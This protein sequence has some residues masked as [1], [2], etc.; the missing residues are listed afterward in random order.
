[1]I[2]GLTGSFKSGKT[3]VAGMFRKKKALVIDADK[4]AHAVIERKTEAWKKIVARFGRRILNAKGA[5]N[6]EKLGE[7][8]FKNKKELNWL[9]G[10]IHP[11]VISEIKALVKKYKKLYPKR[12]IIVDVPLLL[13]AGLGSLVD[14][15]IVVDCRLAEQVKR[16]RLKT[17]LSRI[18]IL[19][20]VNS[21]LPLAKKIKL[22]DFVINNNGTLSETKKQVDGIY[23]VLPR[24]T[25]GAGSNSPLRAH[26]RR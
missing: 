12:I 20:R 1:M 13:E 5:V 14:K 18:E 17:A 19:R 21:Q 6:R 15:I 11:T 10:I 9:S 25:E 8:V 23:N 7:I 26:L 22:A 16:A 24:T 4:L 3:T 2:I